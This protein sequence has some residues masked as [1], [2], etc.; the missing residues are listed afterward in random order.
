MIG[1]R[2]HY[3]VHT[4]YISAKSAEVA[5]LLSRLMPNVGDPRESRRRLLATVAS[6]NML[7]AAP[8]WKD[9][10]VAKSYRRQMVAVY[11]KVCL[12]TV[13]AIRTVYYEAVCVIARM[14][15]VELLVEER[16]RHY[17]RR[18]HV[19]REEEWK[20]TIDQRWEAADSG[21]WTRRLILDVELWY[22]RLHGEVSW[23]RH[24]DLNL[25]TVASYTYTSDER[26]VA[27]HSPQ[28][29]EWTLQIR[30]AQ[31]RDSGVYECQIGTNPPIGLT[32]TLTVV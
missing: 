5:S 26:F 31:L 7:Y 9:A 4:E 3:N 18:S 25:L 6:S 14:P 8:I 1:A 28:T 23:I 17:R 24:R 15:P 19:S 13:S 27:K 30:F 2:L 12:R 21:K 32:M 22:G 10:M 20:I 29:E 11:R 16:I